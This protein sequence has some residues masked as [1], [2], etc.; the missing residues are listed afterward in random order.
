MLVADSLLDSI[1]WACNSNIF[2]QKPPKTAE[3]SWFSQSM[4][5]FNRNKNVLVKSV[6][7]KL[8]ISDL[9]EVLLRSKSYSISIASQ[10]QRTIE[11]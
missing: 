3:V 5:C 1:V 9:R 4:K 10:L 6:A 11:G 2:Q 7:L 8:Q